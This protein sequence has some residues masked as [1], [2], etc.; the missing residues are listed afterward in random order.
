V[1]R[2]YRIA[3][4]EQENE[5]LKQTLI[6]I[7]GWCRKIENTLEPDKAIIYV[8]YIAAAIARVCPQSEREEKE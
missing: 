1:P 4:L 6:D 2:T 7:E 5:K 3:E 8:G